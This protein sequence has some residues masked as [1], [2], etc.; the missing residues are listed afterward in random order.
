MHFE[1]RVFPEPLYGDQVVLAGAELL[2]RFLVLGAPILPGA[3]SLLYE[4][5]EPLDGGPRSQRFAQVQ[6]LPRI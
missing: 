2:Q 4:A 1:V 6:A 5:L 3:P